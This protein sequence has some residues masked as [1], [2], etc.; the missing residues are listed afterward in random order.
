MIF[1]LL[2]VI[3]IVALLVWA[4]RVE[5]KRLRREDAG[6]NLSRAARA[7]KLDAEQRSTELGAGIRSTGWGAA[8]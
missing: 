7:A 6:H 3:P 4:A 1:L 2:I 8:P 5:Q